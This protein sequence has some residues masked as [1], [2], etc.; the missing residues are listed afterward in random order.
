[1]VSV[2]QGCKQSSME[3]ADIGLPA[4]SCLSVGFRWRVDRRRGVSLMVEDGR[5]GNGNRGTNAASFMVSFTC[6]YHTQDRL[7]E[8]F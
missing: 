5:K 3:A 7:L 1:M 6:P 4:S 8:S 2:A